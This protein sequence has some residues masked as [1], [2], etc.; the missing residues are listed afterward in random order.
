MVGD[1]LERWECEVHDWRKFGIHWYV[2]LFF[3]SKA[4]RSIFQ[5]REAMTLHCCRAFAE[6]KKLHMS[7]GRRKDNVLGGKMCVGFR[8]IKKNLKREKGAGCS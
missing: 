2:R 4:E 6:E 8:F 3:V 1:V 7:P 5:G